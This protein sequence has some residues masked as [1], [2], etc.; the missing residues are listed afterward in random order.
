MFG[1]RLKNLRLLHEYTQEQL[2]ELLG[3][4]KQQVYRWE[5]G[6]H[7]PTTDTVE[8]VARIFNVSVDFLLGTEDTTGDRPELK[9]LSPDEQM[10]IRA[11]RGGKIRDI[12]RIITEIAPNV[13]ENI[14]NIEA[15]ETG[16]KKY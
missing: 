14:Q 16:T 1:V 5:S 10:L 7:T 12:L 6:R 4:T 15:P 2:A 9:D 3:T 8:A 11:Y 13:T